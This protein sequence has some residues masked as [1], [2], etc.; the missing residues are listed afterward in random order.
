MHLMRRA[1]SLEKTLMLGKIEGRRRR[2]KQRMRWSNGITDLTDVS[3][4]KLWEIV[5]DGETWCAACSSWGCKES[6]MTSQL[7]KNNTGC[8]CVSVCLCVCVCVC[9]CLCVCKVP[10]D[11]ERHTAWTLGLDVPALNH[12]PVTSKLPFLC[13]MP[14]VG[15]V[16]EKRR[17]RR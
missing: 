14:A 1:D 17:R 10:S 12:R 6:D 9:V 5:R 11:L 7:N 13:S 15:N 8:V 4:R 2:E 16:W 3:L